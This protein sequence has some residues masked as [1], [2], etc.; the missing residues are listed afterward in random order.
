MV[1]RLT[2][3]QSTPPPCTKMHPNVPGYRRSIGSVARGAGAARSGRV[4]A[5]LERDET[6]AGADGGAGAPRS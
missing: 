4:R 2:I 3:S 6:R 1:Q 5:P